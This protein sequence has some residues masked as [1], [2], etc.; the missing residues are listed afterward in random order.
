MPEPEQ[1]K[2]KRGEYDWRWTIIYAIGMLYAVKLIPQILFTFIVYLIR[3]QEIDQSQSLFAH[4]CNPV[5]EHFSVTAAIV[6]ECQHHNGRKVWKSPGA[7]ECTA[8]RW[9]SYSHQKCSPIVIISRGSCTCI[10]NWWA[11][12]YSVLNSFSTD[13]LVWAYLIFLLSL[14]LLVWRNGFE[15]PLTRYCND[16]FPPEWKSYLTTV[17]ESTKKKKE[18]KYHIFCRRIEFNWKSVKCHKTSMEFV[19]FSQFCCH[20]W[21]LAHFRWPKSSS[22][23]H[24][25][26]IG[27]T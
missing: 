14:T 21:K 10:V 3:Q 18:F 13:C 20:R 2:A 16:I 7:Y 6:V 12:T 8:A 19:K 22:L 25:Q 17:K 5:T 9:P 23:S 15:S 27:C 4:L 1:W 26:C 11:L 24:G